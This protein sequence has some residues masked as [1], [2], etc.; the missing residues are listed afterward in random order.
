MDFVANRTLDAGSDL[1]SDHPG[2]QDP[3]YRQRRTILAQLAM[4]YRAGQV[5]P[6]VEYTPEEV[7]TWGKV[8]TFM[9]KLHAQYA[10]AE[11]LHIIPLMEK[12]CGFSADTIPQVQDISAFLKVCLLSQSTHL[13]I[14][15]AFT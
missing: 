1:K 8:Y 4:N 10:C 12:H 5:I 13:F 6:R 14:N 11:Y 2:F 3:I 9:K 15:C 7:A